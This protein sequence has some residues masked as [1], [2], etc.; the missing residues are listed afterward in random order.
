M[1][2]LINFVLFQVTWGAAVWGAAQGYWWLGPVAV[3]VFAA[4]ELLRSPDSTRE[5]K[6][7][8]IVLVLGFAIDTAYI[9]LGLLEYAS[10][11]PW[12]SVAPVWILALW[13]G[14]TLTMNRSLKTFRD[15]PVVGALFGLIGG[16]FAYWIAIEVWDAGA[17][18]ASLPLALGVIGVAWGIAT[19]ILF[20]LARTFDSQTKTESAAA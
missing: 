6:L 10:P 3:I 7:I 1:N 20:H 17:F 14:F 18:T 5:L 13:V 2:N 16:P 9:Q 8:A 15:K 11:V 19:P 12:T 4:V